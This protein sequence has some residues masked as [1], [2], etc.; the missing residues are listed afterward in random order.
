LQIPV[1]VEAVTERWLYAWALGAVA[2]GGASLLVPLYVVQLG[3]TAV[4][5]GVL[6]ATAALVAAPGAIVFG[7]LG[8][9]V[10]GRRPLVVGTLATVALVLAA[11]PL[12]GDVLA[13]VVANAVLWLMVSSI[14]PVLTMLVVDDAPESAW[15]ER[16]GRLNKYQGYGWAGG[17]VLGTVWPFVG[18]RFLAA[19]TVTP[20]LFWLLAGC[21][22]LGVVGAVGSLPRPDPSQHVTSERRIRKIARALSNSR[23]GVKGATFAF[24][25]NRLYW[26]TRDIHPR[27]LFARLDR[28]LALYLIAVVCSFTGF[29]AF[30][31]P[32][33]L[34]FTGIEF[35]SGE[36]FALYLASSVASALLYEGA[37]RLAVR[38]DL[39][40]LQSGALAVRG[41][42]FPA[43]ALVGGL[44]VAA[45]ELGVA[46]V[47][48]AAIGATWAVIAVVGT[49]IVTRL[50]PPSVRG[51]VLG[52]HTALGAV[53]GGVGGVLGGWAATFG[54][55]VA[56][57]VAGGLVLVGA[58]LVFAL[59]F[60]G[61]TP[62]Q[63]AG[64]ADPV[65]ER[66]DAPTSGGGD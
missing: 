12:L 26:T 14:P 5:L 59:R 27:R 4:D 43:V 38:I 8:N 16:I 6:A 66:A 3:G 56:F 54:Y 9:R 65:A 60:V 20:A 10:D 11:I 62:R 45:V 13:V 19:E 53:A 44:G 35:G 49:A 30:W 31:A 63:P 41:L 52:V 42:L 22:G 29:A 40:L 58:G 15:T 21:A 23:R 37:G 33:P 34:F 47:G 17:L 50:A 39:R 24:S 61:E 55:T 36:I 51:E 64:E 46:G 18:G 2:F 1:A 57:G 32:L 7:R 48:L 25:P 28:A